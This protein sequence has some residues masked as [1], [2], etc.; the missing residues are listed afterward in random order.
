VHLHITNDAI[1]VPW[2]LR[3]TSVIKHERL[4][5]YEFR[6]PVL[7]AH[8][9]SGSSESSLSR[10]SRPTNLTCYCS[11]RFALLQGGPSPSTRHS[12]Q[13]FE[14]MF[15]LKSAFK[16]DNP[17]GKLGSE[18]HWPA[19]APVLR[20]SLKSTQEFPSR[21][22]STSSSSSSGAYPCA[23]TLTQKPIHSSNVIDPGSE[24]AR[25]SLTART[26]VFK[27][28]WVQQKG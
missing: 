23:T 25:Q 9:A 7:R 11:E 10:Q 1:K 13:C 19:S 16:V 2:R 6:S 5:R 20:P 17:N 22:I 24:E 27:I 8:V 26:Q 18:A 15:R 28:G 12:Y 4:A 21:S 3:A 14:H